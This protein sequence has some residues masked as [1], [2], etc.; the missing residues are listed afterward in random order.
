MIQ[1]LVVDDNSLR[2]NHIKELMKDL[3]VEPT[4]ITFTSSIIEAKNALLEK[5]FDVMLLDL[6]LPMRK[7]S[8]PL[9]SG[10]HDLLQ[11]IVQ[12]KKYNLPHYVLVIS[13]Y[14]N[15]LENL[16]SI[17]NKLAFSSIKYDAC[18]EE[19]KNR[20][21]NFLQQFLR[22]ELN[23]LSDYQF[24]F[25]VIC[26]LDNPE[27]NEIKRL[28]YNWVSHTIANDS[29]DYYIG[30]V[31]GKKIVCASAYEMGMSA[32]AILATKMILKFKP[33]YLIM[34]GIAGAVTGKGLHFG[35]VMIADPCFDYESG[36]RIFDGVSSIFKPDYR[37]TRLDDKILQ[38]IKRIA[39]KSNVLHEIY[40]TCYY[41]KPDNTLL[42]KIGPFGSGA[43]VL[44]DPKVIERVLE[45][46][47]KFMGFDMEAY[48]V[49]LAGTV[50]P[51]PKPYTIVMKAVSDFGEGKTDVY[52]KYAAY[53]SARVMDLFIQEC[54]CLNF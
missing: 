30:N 6:V 24:D 49:M 51:S 20:L 8:P 19:W 47:R 1:I 45:H 4:Q 7:E 31:A 3:K 2:V 17:S 54:I 32:S 18:C 28:P 42:V 11:E 44:S 29:T 39:G 25:A 23:V 52:Q 38:I 48:S 27:L 22:V 36:K 14:D 13:E 10:G 16:V 15:A 9:N 35:D 37:Q 5:Q 12:I 40:D 21:K 50:A 34:T 43:S 26:A 46:E 33:R 41:E 53:T